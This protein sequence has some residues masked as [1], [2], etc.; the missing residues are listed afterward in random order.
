MRRWLAALPLVALLGMGVL[1]AQ[2]LLRVSV[3]LEH[4]QDLVADFLQA[5]DQA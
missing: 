3:G 1:G 4:A 5:L 2:N